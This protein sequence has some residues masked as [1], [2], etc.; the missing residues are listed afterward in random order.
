MSGNISVL[1]RMPISAWLK[2]RDFAHMRWMGQLLHDRSIGSHT[3]GKEKENPSTHKS[4]NKKEILVTM[5]TCQKLFSIQ[6]I[7]KKEANSRIKL[8]SY[9]SKGLNLLY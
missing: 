6:K 3:Q 2:T 8:Q 1:T 5:A 4:D 9:S 7:F